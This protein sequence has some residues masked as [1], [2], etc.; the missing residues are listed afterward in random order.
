MYQPVFLMP[1]GNMNN[2]LNRP[3]CEKECSFKYK[4]VKFDSTNDNPVTKHAYYSTS[5]KY[6]LCALIYHT[7]KQTFKE[8]KLI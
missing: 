7:L 1:N 4:P 2:Q 8:Y 3:Y 5:P 6:F